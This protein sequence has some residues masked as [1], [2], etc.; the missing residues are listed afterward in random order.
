MIVDFSA[1][2]LDIKAEIHLIPSVFGLNKFM[3]VKYCISSTVK[4]LQHVKT[5]YIDYFVYTYIRSNLQRCIVLT[6]YSTYTLNVKL[7]LANR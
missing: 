3:F 1:L 7:L 6:L 2:F 4:T 5:Y